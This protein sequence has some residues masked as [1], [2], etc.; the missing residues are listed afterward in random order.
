MPIRE[1]KMGQATRAAYGK[2]LVDLGAELPNL[3]GLDADLSKSTYTN[4]FQAKFPER[5]FNCGIA[6]ADMVSIAA[7]LAGAGK[8]P[9]C[10]SFATFLL[11][12]GM[13]QLRISV[14]YAQMNVKVAGTH[15]GI[16]IGEDGPSQQ[17]VEDLA[18]ALALPKF[19]VIVPADEVSAYQLVKTVA[20][21]P[22]AVYLR[23]GR[24]NVP[25][26]YKPEDTFPL[27][28][29]KVLQEGAD[30]TL[31]GHGLH[32]AE[33]L[34]AADILAEKGIAATVIDA[35][36]LKP[37]DHKTLQKY[38]KQTGAIVTA[39]DH[40]IWGGLGSVVAQSLALH[41]PA[42][43]ECVGL[44]DTYAESGSTEELLARYKLLAADIAAKAEAVVAR[45]KASRA[46][47][48]V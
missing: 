13:D 39:E 40:L 30:V 32:V 41:T 47:A 35:Y 28:R 18:L 15:C 44:E 20:K 16:A 43:L 36:C 4:K 6:E 5:H 25:I 7:G 48:Q 19:S 45:K 33:C 38:A 23:L 21:T 31:M 42:L 29:I 12:K 46:L 22:G 37:F 1:L 9:F 11:C 3:V 8:I 10:S 2:A 26:I 14:S 34:K 27:G 17:A 24:A